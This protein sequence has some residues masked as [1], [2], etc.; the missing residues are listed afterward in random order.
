[1]NLTKALLKF[2]I[3][4]YLSM[5]FN[6]ELYAHGL[7]ALTKLPLISFYL[8]YI[9]FISSLKYLFNLKPKSVFAIGSFVGILL[10]AFYT[11]SI[12]VS[13]FLWGVNWLSAFIQIIYWGMAAVL[14]FYFYNVTF[15]KRH[16]E[17]KRLNNIIILY[18]F[19]EL[20]LGS[21]VKY[22]DTIWIWIISGLV[23]GTFVIKGMM[24][25]SLILS[26]A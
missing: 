6:G 4:A 26:E 11:G 10:E 24:N 5:L 2:I 7:S 14:P 13:P 20:L 21:L 8:V 22:P 17:N 19:V 12:F 18:I 9:T 16:R 1:M 15:L 25:K 3:L 23:M